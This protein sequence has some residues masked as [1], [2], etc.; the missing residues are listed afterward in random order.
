MN[1]IYFCADLRAQSLVS[2][3]ATPTLIHSASS[4]M[5][6]TLPELQSELSDKVYLMLILGNFQCCYQLVLPK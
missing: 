4:T 3:W 1:I 5:N 2:L 6:R